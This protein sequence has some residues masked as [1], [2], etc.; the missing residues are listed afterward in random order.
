MYAAASREASPRRLGFTLVELLVVIGIIALLISILLPA[1]SK[2]RA[3]SVQ[4]KCASNMRQ[5]GIA[6]QMYVN[7]N[8]GYLPYERIWAGGPTATRE[9]G[10]DVDASWVHLLRRYFFPKELIVTNNTPNKFMV[11]PAMEGDYP[12]SNHADSHYSMNWNLRSCDA[13]R[14][15]PPPA[16]KWDAWKI[17]RIKRS[18][19][20]MLYVCGQNRTRIVRWDHFNPTK[21]Q[22]ATTIAPHN[23]FKQG[24]NVGYVD[25]HVGF[26]SLAEVSNI[27][28]E[29]R[30]DIFWYSVRDGD[31]TP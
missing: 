26:V 17:T 28:S 6:T 27:E 29:A 31:L 14:Y 12:L 7:G 30:K 21:P 25:G 13:N 3:Q 15:S 2:A 5:I 24:M 1:L 10:A 22:F 23:K 20:V 11:D 9:Y 8:R 18:T 4:V 19:E 16:F